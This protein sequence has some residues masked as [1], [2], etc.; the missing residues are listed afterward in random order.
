M[1]E[2]KG[3]ELYDYQR[4]AVSWMLTMEERNAS[5]KSIDSFFKVI[6]KN[7]QLLGFRG[8]DLDCI[9]VPHQ[10]PVLF[11]R[12]YQR[13]VNKEDALPYLPF[14]TPKGFSFIIIKNKPLLILCYYCRRIFT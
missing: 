1:E 2:P 10:K 6:I 5:S 14:L 7:S 12:K 4:E 3:I 13:F 11:S 9:R 8:L